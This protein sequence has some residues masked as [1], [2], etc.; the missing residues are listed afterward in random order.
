[1][2]MEL[3]VAPGI[4]SG[5]QVPP[6]QSDD[7]GWRVSVIIPAFNRRDAVPRAIA[8][9]LA[10]SLQPLEVIVVDD[11][12]TDNTAAVVQ[13]L[14]RSDSRIRLLRSEANVGGGAARNLGIEAASGEVL[15]FLDSDD[16]WTARHLERGIQA[17]RET[18]GAVLTF[19]PFYVRRGTRMFRQPCRPFKGDPLEYLFY[20]RGG[21]RTSTFVGT[22]AGVRDVMFDESLRKHQ[23]WD[24]VVNL[25]RRGNVICRDEATAILHVASA[26]R[27]SARID[28]AASLQFFRKNRRLS[29]RT[30]WILF[31]SIMLETTYRAE[32]GGGAFRNY[33]DL[34]R[35][36][37]ERAAAALGR[38]TP[39]LR[40][41]R[42][43]RKLFRAAS[44]AWCRA[45]ASGRDEAMA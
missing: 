8:S 19:G 1:M 3:Q 15:A 43:G 45:T 37:D 23:D 35:E 32:Q 31:F 24:L 12:S 22:R 16:E 30:G 11:G 7:A 26:D 28:P 29:T 38:M 40:L 25:C 14:A 5:L 42:I 34:L 21:M 20:G 4:R 41:P 17:L 27:L 13:A 39:L 6:G 44:R 18:P 9:A 2:P 36:T 33:L 10:Q